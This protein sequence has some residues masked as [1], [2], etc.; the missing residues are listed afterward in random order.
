MLVVI[1]LTHCYMVSMQLVTHYLQ[2]GNLKYIAVIFITL[3]MISS[4]VNTWHILLFLV[5]K[6]TNTA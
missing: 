1:L 4:D 6:P 3:S 2:S 5:I